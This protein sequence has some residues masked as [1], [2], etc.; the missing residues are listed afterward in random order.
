M[1]ITP[2]DRALIELLPCPFCGSPARYVEDGDH[3]GTW[4]NLG[5]GSEAPDQGEPCPAHYA[6]YT[7]DMSER[8]AA[9]TAWNTRAQCPAPGEAVAN[10]WVMVPIE[11]KPEM[12]GAFWRVKHGHHFADE[13]APTDTSDY[14]AYRAMIAATPREA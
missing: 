3:H 1:T 10:G 8:D 13:P 11:P 6:F 9:V 2:E 4:F 14:A 5:C 7:C 12:L